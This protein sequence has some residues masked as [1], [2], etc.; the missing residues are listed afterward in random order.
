M[1]V[2]TSGPSF[3]SVKSGRSF[4]ELILND[5]VQDQKQEKGNHCLV[6]TSSILR[7]IRKFHLVVVQERQRNTRKISKISYGAYIFQRLFLRGLYSDGLIYG[8]K[9]AFQN[10]V[11]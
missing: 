9:F 7:E 1:F 8:G 4:L 5:L 10:R 2:K 11:G 6:F 3:Q